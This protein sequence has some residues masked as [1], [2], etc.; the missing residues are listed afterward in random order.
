MA[1]NFATIEWAAA[2]NIYEV[3][4]RQY[5]AEGTFTAF[6]EELPR[7]REMG[8]DILW[9]IPITPISIEKRQGTLGSYYACSDYTS[10]NPEFGSLDEFKSLVNSAH[11][12]GFKVLIDWVAN[13]T[14]WDH[15]WTKE[16]PDFYK[17]NAAGEFYEANGWIDVIDLNYDSHSLR[18]E[19]VEAMKFWVRECNIDGFRC[20]MAHLVPLDFWIDARTQLDKMKP[21]FWL[22]ECEVAEYHKVFDATY[23]WKL[24]H[25]MEALYKGKAPLKDLKKVFEEYDQDF[26]Q[27]ALRLCFTSNHDENSHSGSEYERLGSAAKTFA[28]LC[29]TY[30]NSLPLIYSGQEMPNKKRLLFFFKDAIEWTGQYLLHDFYKVLLGLRK[31]HP[32]MRAGDPSIKTY[33]LQTTSDEN[34]LAFIRDKGEHS[35]LVILNL[36]NNAKLKFQLSNFAATGKYESIF[37]GLE[38]HI[39]DETVFEMQPWEYLVYVK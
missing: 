18:Y 27:E 25:A 6:E 10:T 3:N 21:L 30:K 39:N 13:H 1:E 17:V 38:F 32:A 7:L 2:A 31:D 4:L 23:A 14:G 11:A 36:S 29:A 19:M 22:A 35:V 16:H 8:I 9:F 28:V 12:L 37:S 33:H 34:V 24:L 20:D 5:T 15:K 26:P